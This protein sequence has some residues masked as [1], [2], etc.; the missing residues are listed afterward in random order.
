MF[1]WTHAFRAAC[2]LI[3]GTSEKTLPWYID[4]AATYSN[5]LPQVRWGTV[6]AQIPKLLGVWLTH[7]LCTLMDLKAVELVT[8]QEIDLDVELKAVGVGNLLCAVGGSHWPMY[9]LCSQNVSAYKLGGRTRAVGLI[10]LACVVPMLFLVDSVVPRLPCAL[11]GGVAW[12][13]GIV[14]MKE[15]LLDIVLQHSHGLDVLI[16][17]SMAAVIMYM[18]MLQGI[19]FGL[20]LAMWAFT[21]RYS[22]LA[23]VVRT[24]EN[25]S[26]LHSNVSRPLAQS[27]LIERLGHR[28]AVLHLEGYIMFGSSPQL[29]DTLR[30]MLQP[31]GPSWVVLSFRSVRGLDYSAVC[32]L[33]TIG[34]KAAACGCCMVATE[35]VEGV[36]KSLQRARVHLP[37]L[38]CDPACEGSPARGKAGL[39]YVT[40]YDL[41]LKFCE[42]ALIFS[43]MTPSAKKSQR[44]N[45]HRVSLWRL[46]RSG[47]GVDQRIVWLL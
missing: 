22:D 27:D 46:P 39:F 25:A 14:F 30:P 7:V 36:L 13:M 6:F 43:A 24:V 31:N 17:I 18:G 20:L 38:Q 47:R 15:T 9:M 41:A 1:G 5:A 16:V 12:W 34:R 10:K 44:Q 40:N 33:V 8:Q 26:F 35:L 11:P 32:D 37:E 28:I 19:F 21:L 2:G 29:M 45:D 3:P 23:P 42:D 4:L